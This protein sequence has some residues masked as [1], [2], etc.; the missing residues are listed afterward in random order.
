MS[1][2]YPLHQLR[3]TET[4]EG[5]VIKVLNPI[6]ADIIIWFEMTWDRKG[7]QI[8]LGGNNITFY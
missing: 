7:Q 6:G 8:S 4:N 2:H 5:C 1:N 3:G